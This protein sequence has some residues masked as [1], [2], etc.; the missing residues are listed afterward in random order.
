MVATDPQAPAPAPPARPRAAKPALDVLVLAAIA[1]LLA[2][3]LAARWA[4]APLP[5]ATDTG[6]R[7]PPPPAAPRSAPLRTIPARLPAPAPDLEAAATAALGEGRAA[8]LLEL[9]STPTTRGLRPDDPV[10]QRVVR[11]SRD[12]PG[13]AAV[14]G[15]RLLLLTAQRSA[16][17][18]EASAPAAAA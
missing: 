14:F 18:G 8:R 12:D 4:A 9:V 5:V 17:D 1:A 3:P 7:L 16:A 15:A 11:P 2:F 6:A 10:L 13:A